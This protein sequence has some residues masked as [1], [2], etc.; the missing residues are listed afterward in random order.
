MQNYGFVVRMISL[1]KHDSGNK[2]RA[3]SVEWQS[4]EIL[5]PPRLSRES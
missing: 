2:V 1:G 5:A 3:F 4:C